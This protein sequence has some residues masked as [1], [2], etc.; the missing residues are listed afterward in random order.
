MVEATSKL[1]KAAMKRLLE[2]DVTLEEIAE[3]VYDLQEPYLDNLTMELC[4][5]NVKA[6]LRKRE[7]QN[8]VLTGIELDVLT[9]EGKLA[10]P[11]QEIIE[12]D[13]GLYGIDEVLALAIVNVYGSIGFTNFGY[14][15]KVKPKVIERL[16]SLKEEDEV[17]T[18]L[19]DI[20]GAIAAAAASR[21]AHAEPEAEEGVD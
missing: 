17:N 20:V 19:D 2:R 10:S 16:D 13:E 1:E 5:D 11:L 21:I 3:L 4:L 12:N 14:L 8:A 7:V 15:D 18:F 9:E 6:V